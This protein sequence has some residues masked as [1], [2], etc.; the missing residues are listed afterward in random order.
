MTHEWRASP[1][2]EPRIR[3]LGPVG[4]GQGW[5]LYEV[6]RCGGCPGSA[7]A[8]AAAEL[9]A[10]MMHNA[11]VVGHGP[12][13]L[14]YITKSNEWTVACLTCERGQRVRVSSEV[15][16]HVYFQAADALRGP[17]ERREPRIEVG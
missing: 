16:T 1:D 14:G 3:D 17:C 7:T 9:R 8:R 12:F 10:R 5:E 11:L 6:Q 15:A 2:V 4:P 13:E